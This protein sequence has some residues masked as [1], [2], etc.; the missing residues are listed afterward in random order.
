MAMQAAEAISV[1][2]GVNWLLG[3]DLCDCTFQRIYETTNPFIGSTLRMRLCC[4]WAELAKNYPELVQEIPAYFNGNLRRWE[5]E[6]A[7]WDSEEMDMPLYLWYRQLARQTGK[8]LAEIRVAYAERSDERPKRVPVGTGRKH[9]PEAW[10]VE[11]ARQQL[12]KES[13][14][15]G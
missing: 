13:G 7:D 2:P 15:L 5:T 10:Q 8:S 3:D 4:L 9:E 14:W 11:A 12:L 1:L 6:P